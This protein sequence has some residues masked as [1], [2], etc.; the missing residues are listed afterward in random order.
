MMNWI[1]PLGFL[2]L[3]G[4]A[5]L[6][7]I[8]ILKPNYQ[9]KFISSTFVWKL[10]LKYKRKKIPINK[11]RNILLF[12]CQ[13]LIITACAFI[14][15]QPI[16]E[17]AQAPLVVEKVA[18]ID[19]SA[20]M[21]AAYSKE[22]R[23]E[24]AVF[25]A[26]TLA[27]EVFEQ[28]GYMTVIVAG[29]EATYLMQR[30]TEANSLELFTALDELVSEDLC[31]YGE[32]D[33]TGAIELAQNIVDQNIDTEVYLYTATEYLDAGAVEVVDVSQNGEWNA[34][35]LDCEAVVEENYYTF[36]VSVAA[37]GRDT[38]L[39]VHCDVQGANGAGTVKMER[40][41]RC[42]SDQTKMVTFV[43]AD[44]E[45]PIFEFES[46]HV[47]V[48]ENDSFPQDNDFQIYGGKKPELKVLYCSPKANSFIGG[49]LLTARDTLTNWSIDLREMNKP[50]GKEVPPT[51]GYDFYVFEHVMPD[52]M[53]TDGVVMLIN[54]DK[55]PEGL[56]MVPG[57]LINGDF[58]LAAGEGH[59]I[60]NRFNAEKVEVSQ[61]TRILSYDGFQPLLFCA[62]DPVLLVKEDAEQ[63]ILVMNFSVNFSMVSMYVEF[64]MLIYNIFNHFMPSTLQSNAFEINEEIS[65]NA[66]AEELQVKSSNSNKFNEKFTSFPQ[67]LVL[68]QPGSYTV[69]QTLLS[70]QIQTEQFFVKIPASESNICK[71]EDELDELIVPKKKAIENLD[72]LLYFAAAL[73]ALVILERWL[74]AQDM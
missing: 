42:D 25:E 35:I 74:Q 71:V 34:A 50:A 65:L 1:T 61:Y 68:T 59:P 67:T 22:T 52:V 40:T 70:G 11:F 17:E 37:Y 54:M 21:R 16:I 10:S 7:L 12:I 30:C 31:T 23:F 46:V 5:V 58:T 6:I 29:N 38:D 56:T 57:Q 64:P 66:R 9:Q 4:I 60:T 45:T 32:A 2:G 26:E 43:T 63:K 51:E 49:T 41:E 47:Y 8:Y 18:I 24:R 28:E 55:A 19:A 39:V 20:N 33:I 27:Y 62:G 14:L 15:A 72:L 69:T 13:I 48:S 36:K 53:P 73:V 3:I 44:M